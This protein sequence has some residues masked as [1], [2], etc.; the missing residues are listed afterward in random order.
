MRKSEFRGWKNVFRFTLIETWKNRSF[1]IF[2]IISW[3]IC[4][5]MV[6]VL[7]I[8]RQPKEEKKEYD[9]EKVMIEKAYVLDEV[10][11]TDMGFNVTAFQAEE[12][13]KDVVVEKI[14]DMSYDDL[15]D[16][17]DKEPKSVMIHLGMDASTGVSFNIVRAIESEVTETECDYIGSMLVDEFNKFK[18]EAT[19]MG[20]EQL[21]A[22]ECT[23]DVVAL[24]EQE[25]GEFIT[26][27]AHISETKY[28]ITYA[29]MFIIMMIC[30]MSSTQ[31]GTAVA[32]DKSTKVME[33]LLTSVRPMALVFGK[34]VAQVLSTVLQLGISVVLA[35]LSNILTANLTGENFLKNVLPGDLFSNITAPNLCISLVVIGLGVM[36][37]GFIAGLCGAM[38]SKM[39]E[40]QESLSMLTVIT[41]I[42]VYL[43]M[44]AAMTMQRTL[45]SPLF[46]V[47]ALLPISSPFLLPGICLIG[48][49]S[50]WIKLLSLAILF[51]MDVIIMFA[52]ARIYEI[53]IL[54]NGAT[55]KPKELIK[56]LKQAKGGKGA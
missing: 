6:P 13:F 19:E 18:Y 20:D 2:M 46:Y 30:I 42:G 56:F 22:L 32:M 39:E 45:T 5:F 12:L 52:A 54:Y 8:I 40:L 43:A 7:A 53:L 16:K 47:S 21:K 24:M 50:W 26:E 11:F 23:Y 10:Q 17:V 37:Y 14:H 35:L 41:I 1:L 44:F 38:V 33:Y 55:I 28:W 29:V 49:G 48:V 36:L 27:E 34:V 25:N 4:F 9:I 15:A 3:A 51:V 31:V